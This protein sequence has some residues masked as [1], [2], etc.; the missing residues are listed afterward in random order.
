MDREKSSR[1][2]AIIC[3]GITVLAVLLYSLSRLPFS[4]AL[5][6]GGAVGAIAASLW[7]LVERGRRITRLSASFAAFS[8][9]QELTGWRYDVIIE[10]EGHSRP[11]HI[12]REEA[13]WHLEAGEERI[14]YRT[15]A[16]SSVPVMADYE[17]ERFLRDELQPRHITLRCCGTCSYFAYSSISRQMSSGW[18]AYC[19]RHA[20]GPLLP[21][22]DAV[23]LWHLCG[24]WEPGE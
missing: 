23:H 8:P 4:F 17:L 16:P 18:V 11:A 20:S 6:L 12:W 21:E 24:D 9:A 5:A 14:E 13:T 1:A 7:H 22:K 3:L 10:E 2:I 15:S 19:L